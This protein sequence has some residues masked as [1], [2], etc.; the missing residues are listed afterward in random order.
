MAQI[1][2]SDMRKNNKKNPYILFNIGST[3]RAGFRNEVRVPVW[4]ATFQV[5]IINLFDHETVTY[6]LGFTTSKSILL[7]K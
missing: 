4:D 3:I 5:T 7:I 6:Q 1:C 2:E